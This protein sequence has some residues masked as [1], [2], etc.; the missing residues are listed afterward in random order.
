MIAKRLNKGSTE[1]SLDASAGKSDILVTIGNPQASTIDK[2]GAILKRDKIRQASVT[3]RD[4]QILS[5]DRNI[6][7]GGKQRSRALPG[8]L[9]VEIALIDDPGPHP[10]FGGCKPQRP[11]MIER[12]TGYINGVQPAKCRCQHSDALG[13]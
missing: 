5:G 6:A 7:K 2:S 1:V 13:S 9:R 8:P 12:A 10:A 11:A 4:H 3:M